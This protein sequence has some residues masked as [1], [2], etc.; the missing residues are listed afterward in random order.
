LIVCDRFSPCNGP[1]YLDPED[2]TVVNQLGEAGLIKSGAN[3]I[4]RR[5][6]LSLPQLGY[7]RS[8]YVRSMLS[9]NHARELFHCRIAVKL[10]N[11]EVHAKRL[12]DPANHP[13]DH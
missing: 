11:I 10:Q 9:K 1:R 2:R 4:Y 8:L 3:E 5:L 12:I 6:G 7:R 13:N